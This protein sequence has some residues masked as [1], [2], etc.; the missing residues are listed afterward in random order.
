M[1]TV[2]RQSHE[3]TA[4]PDDGTGATARDL[5]GVTVGDFKIEKLLGRGGMGEVYLATQMSLSRP[6]ALKVLRPNLA[7]NPTYLG[8]L[9]SEATAVAKLNHPNIVHVYTFGNVDL[10]SFI[11][12]EYVQGTNL[13]EYINKKGALDL[14]LAFSIM[15]QTG[16]AIG[17][18]GEVGLVHRDVKPEN[19]LMT[20]KGRVKVADFGL[21][22]DQDDNVHLTQSGVTMGTPLYMSPEQAQGHAIDHR[23]DLYSLGVTYY[24][25]L[26][27][28]PPFHAETALALALKQVREAPRSMLIHRPDLPAELDRLVLKLMAKDPADRFQ[29]AAEMLADLA[30]IRDSVQ[31]SAAT[32]VIPDS[33]MGSSSTRVDDSRSAS[34][35]GAQTEKSGAA[36]RSGETHATIAASVVKPLWTGLSRLS[37]AAIIAICTAALVAGAV[38]GYIARSPDVEAVPADPTTQLPAVWLEP[39]WNT[40]PKQNNADE[41]FRYALLRATPDEWVP[42]FVAVV[43]YFPHAHELRSKAYSQLARI[44]YRRGDL[45][46]LEVLES[47]LSQWKEAKKLDKDLVD[48]VRVAIKLKK[49][50]L[51]GVVQ[52]MK[53]LTRDDVPDTFDSAL[54]ELGI[55]I[56]ADAITAVSRAGNDP[57]RPVLGSCEKQLLRRLYKI[58]MPTAAGSPPSA[59]TKKMIRK[60]SGG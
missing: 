15:R 6:V 29:S 22:R 33:Y 36:S 49:N 52:G 46:A 24:H 30:K 48:A 37:P 1:S 25:M 2:N 19:I 44:W 31:V 43:G 50:D 18:A 26:T 5:T 23:G 47:E 53:A 32:A 13:K 42:A 57:M 16:Q 21:V 17:A 8:R 20:K 38:P 10:I 39:S 41:Q 56:C 35:A 60:Q 7:S 4:W 40:V 14:P 3:D 34:V 45:P 54:L 55:E 58:G 11:A 27:G 59:A 28:V 12:M 51:E 9:K